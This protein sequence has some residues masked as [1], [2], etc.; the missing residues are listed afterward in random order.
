DM[1]GM[2]INTIPTRTTIPDDQPIIS[3]LRELQTT[4]VE[5]R[6]Y[7]YI[8]LT[9]LQAWSDLPAGTNLFNSAVIF[10]NYPFDEDAIADNGLHIDNIHAVDTTNFVLTAVA[11]LDQQLSIDLGYDAALFDT[12]TIH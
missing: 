10:E 4:Q 3:W 5:S 8:A 7:D 11:F 6:R 9:Q 1:I 2:F 12:A